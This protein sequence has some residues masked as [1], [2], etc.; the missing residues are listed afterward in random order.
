MGEINCPHH[1]DEVVSAGVYRS[2]KKGRLYY[3]CHK[4]GLIMGTLPWLQVYIKKHARFN[5]DIAALYKPANDDNYESKSIEPAND[6]NYEQKK[7]ANS[8]EDEMGL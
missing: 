6:D 1:D 5:D 3:N 8:F 4:C 2:L 7:R